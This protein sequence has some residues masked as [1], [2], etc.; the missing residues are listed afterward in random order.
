MRRKL[1]NGLSAVQCRHC[2]AAT[3]QLF[4]DVSADEL[5]ATK[6]G[7]FIPG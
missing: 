5:C 4:D 7:T 3:Q 1:V 2:V 6:N